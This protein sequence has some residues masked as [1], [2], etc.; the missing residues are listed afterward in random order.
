MKTMMNLNNKTVLLIDDDDDFSA[1]VEKILTKE[2]VRFVRVNHPS[3][4]MAAIEKKPPD[5]IILDLNFDNKTDHAS[6]RDD[7][8]EVILKLRQQDE[9]LKTIPVI[10]CS[11]ENFA[12][13]FINVES[14]GANDYIS[15]PIST[16]SLIHKLKRSLQKR[17]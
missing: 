6:V 17:E 4:A 15:K 13:T 3:K 8:G 14:I 1:F 10:V 12:G 7:H 5:I 9:H 16:N 11:S 2:N